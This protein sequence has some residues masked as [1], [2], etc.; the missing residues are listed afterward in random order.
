MIQ[1]SENWP[2]IIFKFQCS[3]YSMFSKVKIMTPGDII[4]FLLEFFLDTF[5]KLSAM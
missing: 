2:Q 1:K 3:I 4:F 5:F